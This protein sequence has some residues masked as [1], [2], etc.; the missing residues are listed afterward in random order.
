[1]PKPALS[2]MNGSERRKRQLDSLRTLSLI[3][4]ALP[5]PCDTASA[6]ET[7]ESERIA[8]WR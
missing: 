4:V 8:R 6:W 5:L 7:A 3:L 1:M 2:S